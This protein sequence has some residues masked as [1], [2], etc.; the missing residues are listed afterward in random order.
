MLAFLVLLPLG[1][2]SDDP[3]KPQDENRPPTVTF[4]YNKIATAS[5][6]Q[7]TLT[8][9]V[10][11]ADGDVVTVTW[12][13]SS[14]FLNSADQGGTSM[15][16]T[17]PVTVGTDTVTITATDGNGGNTTIEEYLTIGTGVSGTI[18]SLEI[19]NLVGSPYVVTSSSDRLTITAG[20]RLTIN[21]GVHVLID[22]PLLILDVGGQ[23]T[24]AGTATNRVEIRANLAGSA[25]G[26]WEG[27]LGSGSGPLVDLDYTTLT[28]AVNAVK[29]VANTIVRLNHCT[30]MLCSEDAILHESTGELVVENSAITNNKRSGIRVSLL[31][32]T[33]DF[34]T[35]RN[36]SI[37]VNGL[38]D[39]T[40]YAEGEAGI[41]L[42]FPDQ[43]G[44]VTVDIFGNEI[45]RNDF[46]GIHLK[47]GVFPVINNNGIF[48]N[49]LLKA[50]NKI[51]IALLEPFPAG[52]INASG[53]WWGQVYP[54]PADSTTIRNGIID[55]EDNSNIGTS[56]WVT[57]WLGSAP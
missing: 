2:C 14:G 17:A 51:Q 54:N 50:T 42:D 41:S 6:T 23:L 21:P 8:V 18:S 39:G 53:N 25:E 45:S 30:I 3:S 27:I 40:P 5:G 15:R 20:G 22:K 34:I 35:I 33:P 49:E 19:W 16:W 29:A 26:Y 11:D 36:D 32:G 28:H 24:A 44:L 4:T 1:A 57:P 52:Q 48:G 38:F 55:N 9:V 10:D 56:V 31:T 47:T 43:G 12:S 13:S 37:A 7:A 46:P